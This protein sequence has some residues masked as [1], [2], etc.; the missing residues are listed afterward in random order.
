MSSPHA[1]LDP[2]SNCTNGDV[3]LMDKRNE[4]SGRVEFCVG[5]FWRSL[6][7]DEFWTDGNAQVVCRQLGYENVESKTFLDLYIIKLLLLSHRCC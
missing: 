5:G 1:L 6:C 2:T 3:R 4:Y 7:A